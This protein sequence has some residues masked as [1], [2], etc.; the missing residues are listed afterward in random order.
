MSVAQTSTTGRCLFPFGREE[1]WLVMPSARLNLTS[2]CMPVI[3]RSSWTPILWSE[4]MEEAFWLA[5]RRLLRRL[6]WKRVFKDNFWNFMLIERFD[7]ICSL[8]LENISQERISWLLCIIDGVVS[9]LETTTYRSLHIQD[10]SMKSMVKELALQRKDFAKNA[11]E[12]RDSAKGS[13]FRSRVQ[14]RVVSLFFESLLQSLFLK[15]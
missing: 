3:F 13:T 14:V 11:L 2:K 5:L 4:D 8:F 15:V 9:T 12:F 7:W 10:T 1:V 6:Y